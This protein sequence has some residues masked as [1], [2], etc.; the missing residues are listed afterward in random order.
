MSFGS[1]SG[2]AFETGIGAAFYGV[3]VLIAVVWWAVRSYQIRKQERAE[4][5]RGS[6]TE[7]DGRKG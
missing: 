2:R 1:S 7:E 3:L 5:A 4:Q 6:A